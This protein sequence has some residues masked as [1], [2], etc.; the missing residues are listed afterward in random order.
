MHYPVISLC[1]L[2]YL[3]LRRIQAKIFQCI[4]Y[5]WTNTIWFWPLFKKIWR[6]RKESILVMI[7]FDQIVN[8]TLL[9][10]SVRTSFSFG[11]V[12]GSSKSFFTNHSSNVSILIVTLWQVFCF[13]SSSF[14]GNYIYFFK[15]NFH[16]SRFNF[17]LD[18]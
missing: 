13:N 18:F 1:V 6:Q 7:L 17:F 15:F 3:A 8:F 12:I 16:T 11:L 5:D 14:L 4:K 9:K 10:F 2:H